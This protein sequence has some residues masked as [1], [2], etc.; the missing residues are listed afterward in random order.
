MADKDVSIIIATKNRQSDLQRCVRSVG[1]Q[2][3]IPNEVIIVDDGSLTS[4][5]VQELESKLDERTELIHTESDGPPGLSV[6]RNTGIRE[7][8][9]EITLVVDD[10]TELGSTYIEQ[11]VA[12]YERIDDSDFVGVAGYDSDQRDPSRLELLFRRIFLLGTDSWTVNDIGMQ[13]YAGELEEPVKGHWMPG[14]NFSHRREVILDHLFPQ[15]NGGRESLEDIAVGWELKKE[16]KYCIIDPE[17]PIQHHESVRN[18]S[19]YTIGVK[20]GKNRVRYF[21]DYGDSYR[22]PM[23]LWGMLGVV[24][25]QVATPIV[26]RRFYYHWTKMAGIIVGTLTQL[27]TKKKE[28]TF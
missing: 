28:P 9:S 5:Y 6:A 22:W 27:M 19:G 26:N 17:L 8:S 16:G 2:T 4:S 10:D 7:A 23:F 13:S 14:Y 20:N 15:Y 11:L 3:T 25:L 24:L 1:E 21:K 18:D 12:W